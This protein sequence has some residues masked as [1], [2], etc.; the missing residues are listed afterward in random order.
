MNILK[1]KTSLKCNGCVNAIKPGMESISGIRMW[2]VDLE[3]SDRVLEV[4]SEEDVSDKI[5][6]N[7]KK[8]GYEISRL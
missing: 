2:K 3:T 4:E 8:A 6:D 7:I 5:L 1:F